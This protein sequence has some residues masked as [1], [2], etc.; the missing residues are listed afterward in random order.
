MATQPAEIRMECYFD[1]DSIFTI[2]TVKQEIF[3]LPSV[4]HQRCS[5]SPFL[6]RYEINLIEAF[7]DEF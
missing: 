5:L 1:Y 3:P 7:I 4:L 2:T 6:H